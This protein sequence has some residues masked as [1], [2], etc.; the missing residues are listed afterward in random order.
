MFKKWPSMGNTTKWYDI[1][2]ESYMLDKSQTE[3]ILPNES[4][5]STIDPLFSPPSTPAKFVPPTCAAQFRRH[6][7]QF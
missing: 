6:F 3:G 1:Q 4:C 2:R 7:W 5:L